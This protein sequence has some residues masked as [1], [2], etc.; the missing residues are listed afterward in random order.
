MRS[1]LA[2]AKIL[3]DSEL[4]GSSDREQALATA[5]HELELLLRRAR[6]AH[7]QFAAVVVSIL[8]ELGHVTR[9]R[10]DV[11]AA[12]RYYGEAHVVFQN[13]GGGEGDASDHEDA[14]GTNAAS[15]DAGDSAASLFT[16]SSQVMEALPRL[17]EIRLQRG[18][19][20]EALMLYVLWHVLSVLPLFAKVASRI[21]SCLRWFAYRRFND[22]L[23]IQERVIGSSSPGYAATLLAIGRAQVSHGN[24][25]RGHQI[26]GDALGVYEE[27][28]GEDSVRA[29]SI[30]EEIKRAGGVPPQ[31]RKPNAV[32]NSLHS[33]ETNS[34]GEIANNDRAQTEVLSHVDRQESSAST[35][36]QG[37]IS[38]QRRRAKKARRVLV[39]DDDSAEGN[40]TSKC[41]T[42][43]FKDW[44]PAEIHCFL[45]YRV[46]QRTP[47]ALH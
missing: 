8:C 21:S 5:Q 42:F 38:S 33:V 24:A 34:R 43:D 32:H 6:A 11:D 13:R 37:N 12:I 27:V 19:L 17:A 18:Q 9:L 7:G 16:V 39:D 4:E 26:L 40:S 20:A 1:E 46:L 31:P 3:A 15:S 25:T 41:S 45:H 44:F 36:K 10:G 30:R 22:L 23:E 47:L 35:Q 29:V 14:G 2:K 28:Y